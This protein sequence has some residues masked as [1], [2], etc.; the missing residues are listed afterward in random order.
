M[1]FA[2][3]STMN[4]RSLRLGYCGTIPRKMIWSKGFF[5]S[6][7]DICRGPIVSTCSNGLIT[8]SRFTWHTSTKKWRKFCLVAIHNEL[9]REKTHLEG[10]YISIQ[11]V[12]CCKQTTSKFNVFKN[13]LKKTVLGKQYKVYSPTKLQF[14]PEFLLIVHSDTN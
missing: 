7:F 4:Q 1:W 9:K 12:R 5:G 8:M 6:I 3:I 10:Q 11:G 13:F 14:S 2:H